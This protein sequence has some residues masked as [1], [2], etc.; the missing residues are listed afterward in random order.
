MEVFLHNKQTL[1][2]AIP[3]LTNNPVA[4]AK[5]VTTFFALDESFMQKLESL[6]NELS[7]AEHS[8]ATLKRTIYILPKDASNHKFVQDE[9]RLHE[10]QSKAHTYH[11]ILP[12]LVKNQGMVQ[13]FIELMVVH[14]ASS[15]AATAAEPI[16]VSMNASAAFSTEEWQCM[17]AIVTYWKEKTNSFY[18]LYQCMKKTWE[19][20]TKT[21]KVEHAANLQALEA[22]VNS[23]LIDLDAK[24]N[25]A[26]RDKTYFSKVY[27]AKEHSFKL[28]ASDHEKL[29]QDTKKLKDNENVLNGDILVLRDSIEKLAKENEDFQKLREETSDQR[30]RIDDLENDVINR[31]QEIDNLKVLLIEEKVKGNTD[32]VVEEKV[33]TIKASFDKQ[34][35]ELQSQKESLREELSHW[36]ESNQKLEEIN[37]KHFAELEIAKHFTDEMRAE[38]SFSIYYPFSLKKYIIDMCF[39][40][41]GKR[42]IC[43]IMQNLFESDW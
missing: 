17:H 25:N 31:K 41:L 10:L 38:V 19:R 2:H 14:A 30:K 43:G 13:R 15:T 24:W 33:Q 1:F 28:L 36:K 9:I 32:L 20:D 35:Q 23:K 22:M 40:T 42:I 34:I 4:Y 37:K 26:E 5:D 18:I 11:Q 12:V 6:E 16:H 39:Q 7:N 29:Q 21:L 8:F 27:F 3:Q